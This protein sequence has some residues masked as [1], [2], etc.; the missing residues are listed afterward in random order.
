MA[1]RGVVLAAALLAPAAPAFSQAQAQVQAPGPANPFSPAITVN[2]SAITYYDITQRVRLIEALGARGDTR[3][4]AIEQLTE[5]R[6]KMQAAAELGIELPEGAVMTGIEEFASQRGL[7]VDD[8]FNVLAQREIDRQTMDDFV[9]AG[10]LWRDVVQTRFRQKAMPSETDLDAALALAETTPVDIVQFSEIALPFAERGEP[11][12]LALADR[13]SAQLASGGNFAAAAREYSRSGTAPQ[14]GMLEPV[15]AAQ[16]PPAMR[17]QILLLQPGG[18][19]RPIPISGGVAI[20]KLN[21]VRQEMRPPQADAVSDE[22]ARSLL[23][24]QVFTQRITSF[25]QG[26]LQELLRDALI[27]EK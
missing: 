13:L 23:R 16:L 25:G 6:V 12:T 22:E 20:L 27:V 17:S 1:W 2:D 7:T 19:T 3:Q 26:Y 5:D 18:V 21:S 8:V 14:G 4:I 15:P 10:L 9:E 11:E 24:E